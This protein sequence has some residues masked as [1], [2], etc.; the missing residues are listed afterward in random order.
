ML[1]VGTIVGMVGTQVLTC[2]ETHVVISLAAICASQ[3]E[4]AAIPNPRMSNSVMLQLS[5]QI[6]ER[7]NVYHTGN[8][9]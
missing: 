8:T 5:K 4:N 2:G 7:Q 9:S 3:M 6:T 1:R